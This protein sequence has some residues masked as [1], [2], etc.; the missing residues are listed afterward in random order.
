MIT[1]KLD[2]PQLPVMAYPSYTHVSI[3]FTKAGDQ[4]FL[5]SYLSDKMAELAVAHDLVN[6]Q[7]RR[8]YVSHSER[9]NLQVE[10]GS[11]KL[12]NHHYAKLMLTNQVVNRLAAIVSELMFCIY[13]MKNI[14]NGFSPAQLSLNKAI[15]WVLQHQELSGELAA[16]AELVKKC[17][18]ILGGFYIT[19][20]RP[21]FDYFMME[22]EPVYFLTQQNGNM[23]KHALRE[24]TQEYTAFFASAKKL[25]KIHAPEAIALG[26]REQTND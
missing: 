21:A 7:L 24:L 9:K 23:T 13:F 5:Y 8:I 20:I 12:D 4:Y 14:K 6:E 17:E 15:S 19:A 10:Y 3:R 1:L 25:L 16:Y 22:D 2:I 11:Y 18:T 26:I